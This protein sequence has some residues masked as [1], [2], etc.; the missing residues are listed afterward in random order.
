MWNLSLMVSFEM[1]RD[2]S[3]FAEKNYLSFGPTYPIPLVVILKTIYFDLK[4]VRAS[5]NANRAVLL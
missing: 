1:K 3:F 2:S 4:H 5:H